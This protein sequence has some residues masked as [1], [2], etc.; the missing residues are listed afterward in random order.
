MKDSRPV[1]S[2]TDSA[3]VNTRSEMVLVLVA[4]LSKERGIA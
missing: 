4:A 1:R 3:S 2:V